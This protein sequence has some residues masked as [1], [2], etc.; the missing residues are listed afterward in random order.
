MRDST[1]EITEGG[2][3]PGHIHNKISRIL[4]WHTYEPVI[5]FHKT[6]NDAH[7]VAPICTESLLTRL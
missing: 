6:H 4:N 1:S 5:H 2:P 7:C 3:A